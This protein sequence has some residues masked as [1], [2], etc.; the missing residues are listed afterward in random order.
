M[1]RR[2]CRHSLKTWAGK[3]QPSISGQWGMGK[4]AKDASATS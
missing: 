4:N 2:V 3:I 1:D